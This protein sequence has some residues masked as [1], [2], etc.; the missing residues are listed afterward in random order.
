MNL[1]R[2][3][4][5]LRPAAAAF[6]V[7]GFVV[8]GRAAEA[9]PRTFLV[10]PEHYERMKHE[11]ARGAPG[12]PLRSSAAALRAAA[13]KALNAGPWSVMDKPDRQIGPSGDKHD[14]VSMSSYWWPD[15]NGAYEW[16]DGKINPDMVFQDEA[17]LGDLMGALKTLA[18]AGY[19]LGDERYTERAV[20]LIECWFLDPATRMNPN[21]NYAA[22]I[23][24]Q[25]TGRGY[26]LHRM[27]EM[28][29]FVDVL[30]LVALSPRWGAEREATMKDWVAR[31][32]AWATTSELGLDEKRQ[33]NNHAVY[34]GALALAAALYVDD[35]ANI[36]EFSR[37]FFQEQLI[38]QIAPDGALPAEM[39]R[40][41][42]YNYTVYTLAGFCQYAELAHNL[43]LDYYHF[44]GP[45]GQTLKKAFAWIIPF[46]RG[47]V[48]SPKPDEEAMRLGRIFVSCRLAAL[49]CDL[50]FFESYLRETFPK[51]SDEPRNLFWPPAP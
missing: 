42:P 37:R 17:A 31:Y 12:E 9:A 47:D 21:L 8:L 38:K 6:C 40:S 20:F 22:G 29:T 41:R 44:E 34:Y 16:R 51:W 26:G 11:L 46:L 2:F 49:R 30:G 43:G 36:D 25:A 24:G 48:P 15:A 27:K 32:L 50:P 14:Y 19:L 3:L 33:P 28:P 45:E 7:F 10:A 23:P 13:D 35:R 1:F 18:P 39:V 5:F 4:R